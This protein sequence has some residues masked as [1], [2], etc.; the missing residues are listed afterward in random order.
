M[1]A[2]HDIFDER[3]EEGGELSSTIDFYHYYHVCVLISYC[4]VRLRVDSRLF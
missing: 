3:E 2:G 1:K 4:I